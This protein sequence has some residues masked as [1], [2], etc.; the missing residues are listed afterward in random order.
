MHPEISFCRTVRTVDKIFKQITEDHFLRKYSHFFKKAKVILFFVTAWNCIGQQASTQW[1]QIAAST[2]CYLGAES[3]PSIVALYW[4]HWHS[5]RTTALWWSRKA[6]YV[7]VRGQ[8]GSMT[9]PP[10]RHCFQEGVCSRHLTSKTA[11]YACASL[12][13]AHTKNDICFTLF[14]PL[15]LPQ[16]KVNITNGN[17]E[18]KM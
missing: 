2:V 5:L 8:R 4:T 3:T 13:S 18:L 11:W 6:L 16:H 12:S 7:S 10:P 15:H 9:P 1:Q 17:G 14:S